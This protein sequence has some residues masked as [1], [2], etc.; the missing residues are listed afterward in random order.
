MANLP[1]KEEIEREILDIYIK[2]GV[3]EGEMLPLANLNSEWMK[4]GD[5]FRGDD[6]INGINSLINEGVLEEQEGKTA[7]FLTKKGYE[8]L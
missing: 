3:R 2:F 1:S 5:R 6:L 7:V 8:A 4:K